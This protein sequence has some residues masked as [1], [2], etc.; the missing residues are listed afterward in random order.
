MNI[1]I[2]VEEQIPLLEMVNELRTALSNGR[3]TQHEVLTGSFN[4]P[5]LCGARLVLAF[6]LV[7]KSLQLAILGQQ[8]GLL[9]LQLI[10]IFRSLLKYGSLEQLRAF[11]WN[12]TVSHCMLLWPRQTLSVCNHCK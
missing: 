3:A 10:D 12:S 11:L 1:T 7:D 5:L 6:M 8:T 4:F 2:F 9:L